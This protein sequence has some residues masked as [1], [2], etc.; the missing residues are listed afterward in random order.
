T[1]GVPPGR[2]TPLIRPTTGAPRSG[3]LRGVGHRGRGR[4]VLASRCVARTVRLDD[5][6]C[7]TA[8]GTGKRGGWAAIFSDRIANRRDGARDGAEEAES[9][10]DG[11]VR[12]LPDVRG[13]GSGP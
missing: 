13:W 3:A 4:V 2:G 6:A 9:C 8:E 1:P 11:G 7:R 10:R 12:N 5:S